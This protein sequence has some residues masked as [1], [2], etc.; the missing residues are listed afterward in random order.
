MKKASFGLFGI[1]LLL[2][3]AALPALGVC[4]KGK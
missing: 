4:G 2:S 1:V 3:L